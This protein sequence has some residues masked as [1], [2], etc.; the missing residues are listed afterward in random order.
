MPGEQ[1]GAQSAR[2]EFSRQPPQGQKR[3]DGVKRVPENVGGVV[4]VRGLAE[5]L[6]I[7]Q[8]GQPGKGKP[9][10][11]RASGECPFCPR[12]R[13]TALYVKVAG[14]VIRIVAINKI[15]SRR[16]AVQQ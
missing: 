13:K 16:M 11:G 7:Q 10:G 14:D 3:Q 5:K 8:V 2:P 9:V 15:V 4:A 12:P 1:R 6:P